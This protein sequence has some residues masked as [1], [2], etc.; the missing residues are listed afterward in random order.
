MSETDSKYAD[1]L[2]SQDALDGLMKEAEELSLEQVEKGGES[3]DLDL[4]SPE[5][6]EKLL[7]K[8]SDGKSDDQDESDLNLISQDDIDALISGEE[9]SGSVSTETE[10]SDD[11][12]ISQDDIDALLGGVDISEKADEAGNT[13]D[14]EDSL[15]SQGDIDALS[16][17]E[18]IPEKTDAAGNTEGSED[19]LISQDD[20][21]ALLAG[22]DTPQKSDVTGNTEESE[23]SLISQDDID[24]LLSGDVTDTSDELVIA[25]DTDTSLISQEDI[26]SLLN[27]VGSEKDNED[28]QTITQDD[29]E[30][31]LANDENESVANADSYTGEK[32]VSQEDI[33]KLLNADIDDTNDE[34]IGAVVDQVILEK[35]D[36]EKTDSQKKRL[37]EWLTTKKLIG[38]AVGAVLLIVAGISIAVFSG[39][40]E[41][42]IVETEIVEAEI[43]ESN[44]EEVVVGFEEEMFQTNDLAETVFITV[45]LKDF[46]VPAPLAMKNISYL[47]LDLTLEIVDVTSD[48]I[49][50]YEPFFRNIIYEVLNK[51]LELQ[52]ESRIIEADLIRMLQKALN[53]ALSEGSINKVSFKEFNIT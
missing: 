24:A 11:S 17:E 44:Q 5:D 37:N 14:S 36:E 40:P 27:D 20:I 50:G 47:S 29:I 52:S 51:A 13:D 12:L 16:G 9:L 48:P 15:I 10:D 45:E 1:S 41:E 42:E 18:D 34:V 53:D 3:K 35:G 43:V 32:L 22:A 39:S 19:S 23:D 8:T 21:D 31:L 26:D 46:V 2:I 30:N 38:C 6:I 7:E 28:G 33:D 49:K 4:V 25:D